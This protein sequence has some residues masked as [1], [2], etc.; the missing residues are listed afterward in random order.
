MFIQKWITQSP[1]LFDASSSPAEQ[2]TD[3]GMQGS[4]EGEGHGWPN[5]SFPTTVQAQG[6][7]RA[8]STKYHVVSQRTAYR[9]PGGHRQT[10]Q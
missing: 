1:P 6:G 3:P 10:E 4:G 8:H 7:K 9:K 2:E 5:T